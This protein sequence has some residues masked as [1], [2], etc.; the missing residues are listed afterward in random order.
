MRRLTW[1]S[2]WTTQVDL[3]P[4]GVKIP[5]VTAERN[6]G[7]QDPPHTHTHSPER[8]ETPTQTKTKHVRKAVVKESSR[9]PPGGKL[10][11]QS[12]HKKPTFAGTEKSA[13]NPEPATQ[14][15][16]LL[17]NLNDIIM[18]QFS[19][20]LLLGISCNC[21]ASRDRGLLRQ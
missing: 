18:R 14:S 1:D 4:I 10:S 13:E 15:K 20:V 11:T 17:E 12:K 5:H 21:Y 19:T 8:G 9:R 3:A 16:R 2:Y 7:T 6:I